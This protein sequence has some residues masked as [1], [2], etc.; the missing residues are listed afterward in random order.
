[1]DPLNNFLKGQNLTFYNLSYAL[2]LVCIGLG[3]ATGPV[4]DESPPSQPRPIYSEQFSSL[5]HLKN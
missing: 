5:S 3:M 2:G 4:R 1:M